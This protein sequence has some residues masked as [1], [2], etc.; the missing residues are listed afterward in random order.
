MT[1]T[2]ADR[3]AAALAPL[4]PDGLP[5]RLHAWDGSE[6]GAANG[7]RLVLRTPDA[8]RHLLWAPGE[9]GLARAYVTGALDVEGDLADGLSRMNA[10]LRRRPPSRRAIAST[11]RR[12]IPALVSLGAVGGRPAVPE[13]EAR[14]SGRLHSRKRDAGVIAHHYDLSNALYRLLLDDNM[15]YSCAYWIGD[16][17]DY[18]LAD[19]QRDK[20]DLICTKLELHPGARLLDVGCGWGSLSV[21]AG[22]QFGAEVT[23][24]TLSAEQLDYATERVKTADVTDLVNLHRLDYR[25][26]PT[27]GFGEFDAVS[28]I[29]M[30]EHVGAANYPRFLEILRGRLRPGGH[31]LIQQM[32]RRSRPGGGP[33]IERY[34]AP[35]MHMRP[36]GETVELIEAAGFEVRDVHCLREHYVTTIRC[37]LETFEERY[38]EVVALLGEEQARV[39]R[40]YLVGGALAFEEG[41]MGVD[42]I[43]AVR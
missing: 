39:W 42:Q 25:D 34:I 14:V 2:A 5:L 1:V 8:L 17:P 26:L 15:A 36:L 32:S 37:W 23:G 43:L 19:A 7:P 3:L 28:A 27:A 9:L 12:A 31:L 40:L 20:L 4:F 10:L 22:A 13:A 24:I 11:V 16:G 35:D 29:E 33:F 18:T 6:A 21:H 38:D 41:R 30:G